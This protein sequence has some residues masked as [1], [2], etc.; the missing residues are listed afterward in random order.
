MVLLVDYLLRLNTHLLRLELISEVPEISQHLLVTEEF[1]HFTLKVFKSVVSTLKDSIDNFLK[2]LD[3]HIFQ[4]EL[5]NE[6]LHLKKDFRFRSLGLFTLLFKINRASSA[7]LAFLLRLFQ[8]LIFTLR[9]LH[10]F[11]VFMSGVKLVVNGIRLFTSNV[12][13]GFLVFIIL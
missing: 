10:I 2:H 1:W 3:L 11:H 13:I 6:S 7:D 5:F 4:A 9:C 12:L 8:A